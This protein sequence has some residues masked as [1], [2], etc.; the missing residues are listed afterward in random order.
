MSVLLAAKAY[1]LAQHRGQHRPNATREPIGCHLAEVSSYVT[2]EG[3][4]ELV[5]AAAW[6]H[7]VIEDTPAT[8]ADLEARFGA[9]VA[10]LV[11]GLTDPEPLR[12]LPLAKR[13]LAQAKRLEA[14][15]PEVKLIKLA[16]QLSNLKS[17]IDDPPLAWDH[18][19]CQAYIAGALSV[20]DVC[21]GIAPRLDG[22]VQLHRQRAAQRYG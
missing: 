16:D 13:K 22:L 1:A 10:R 3:A 18:P 20:A 21:R 6:L 8:P 11:A 2:D 7:D 4:P 12:R 19:T 15:P 9:D 17:V 5:I 14:Q